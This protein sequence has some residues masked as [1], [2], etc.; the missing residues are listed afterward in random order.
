[1]LISTNTAI[2]FKSTI[3]TEVKKGTFLAYKVEQF[4]GTNS[5]K[6]QNMA[7]AGIINT[8]VT[9]SAWLALSIHAAVALQS[10]ASLENNRQHG[11]S[12]L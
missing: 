10:E 9:L 1:M 5:F 8:V 6:L 12:Y 4:Q 7:L 2:K 3:L 11:F